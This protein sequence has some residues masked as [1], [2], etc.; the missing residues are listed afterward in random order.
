MSGE[1]RWRGLVWQ[2][3]AGF[4]FGFIVLH[5]VSMVIFQMLDPRLAVPMSDDMAAG[6]ADGMADGFLG[7]IAHSFRL[8][9]W[10]MGMVFGT[11]GA[12]IATSYG[13]HR[14][15]LTLQRDLLAEQL[16]HN[17]RLRQDLAHQAG[18]L[19]RSNQVLAELELANR[20]TAQFMAHD[21]KTALGCVGGF[22]NEL[23]EKPRLQR[24]RE[25]ADALACIRRQAH[26]M[27]G[28]VTDLLEFARVREKREPQM[29]QVSVT[30]LLQEAAG[31]FSLPAQT[32]QVILGEHYA[33]CPPLWADPRLLRRVLCNLIS[34]AIKHNGPATRVW[35]DAKV[36]ESGEFVVFGCR[37]DGAGIPPEVL[38]SIFTEFATTGDRS[39]ESTGLGLA[40]CKAVVEAH[41]G[42]IWCKSTPAA[43]AS[44]SDP[45]G[46]CGA[47]FYF[48]I[49]LHKESHNGQ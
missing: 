10:P 37:D 9:M 21:F 2:A 35:L 42:R 30:A 19:K 27:M 20:R 14:L 39:G 34:N 23:L 40:F 11:V 16:S 38:P 12:A 48:T 36:D 5:P 25:V 45:K 41:G 24:D 17:E 15:T 31:D 13:Y 32:E 49:P 28:S 1:I 43:A 29:E 44:T 26:R 46:A 47:R 8:A 18:L 33:D 3:L 4:L 22:A 6:K 7:P